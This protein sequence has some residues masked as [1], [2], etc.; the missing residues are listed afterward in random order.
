MTDQ[1]WL[2]F[3]Y[4]VLDGASRRGGSHKLLGEPNQDSWAVQF[5]ENAIVLSVSDG[6]GSHEFSQVGS[7]LACHLAT[8]I[9]AERFTQNPDADITSVV[10]EIV[11]KWK[12]TTSN[13]PAKNR[14]GATL[15]VAVILN[16][17][18]HLVQIGDG[19]IAYRCSNSETSKWVE[20]DLSPKKAALNMLPYH[21]GTVDLSNVQIVQEVI[22]T[23][24]SRDIDGFCLLTDGL[25]DDI[26][27][28]NKFI[29]RLTEELDIHNI[30]GDKKTS[31]TRRWSHLETTIFAEWERQI[32]GSLDDKTMVLCLKPFNRT[33]MLQPSAA[34]S[35]LGQGA[36][37]TM[38][39][40]QSANLDAPKVDLSHNDNKLD[41][42]E[43]AHQSLTANLVDKAS[44]IVD[45]FKQTI[46]K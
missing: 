41:D 43:N 36:K 23:I 12:V 11:D 15:L 32:P 27:D 46:K 18:C 25:S 29:R 38:S 16:H 14:Y 24:D 7:N 19:M 30:A 34:T 4:E 31:E 28:P 45:K 17:K 37:S 39:I 33:E 10:L 26:A 42:S 6:L 3:G 35:E 22:Q 20:S 44:H 13:L 2:P 8:T 9:A 1:Q 21:I 5:S 40:E